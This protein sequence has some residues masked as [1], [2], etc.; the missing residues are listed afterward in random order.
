[1]GRTS[2]LGYTA[3]NIDHLH[4]RY[5]CVVMGRLED[6]ELEPSVL[7][8][9]SAAATSARKHAKMRGPSPGGCG[10]ATPP[11][12]PTKPSISPSS[13][14]GQRSA[15]EASYDLSRVVAMRVWECGLGTCHVRRA[16]RLRPCSTQGAQDVTEGV[17]EGCKER[18]PAFSIARARA[19]GFGQR[20]SKARCTH[21]L[22]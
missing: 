3:V 11:P 1:M 2:R 7:A 13:E 12:P 6:H 21:R 14:T 22:G 19:L 9:E 8:R 17:G 16:G 15:D 20:G 10:V 4:R 18:M 5:F